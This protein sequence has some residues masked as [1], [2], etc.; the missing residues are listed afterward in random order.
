MQSLQFITFSA[1]HKLYLWWNWNIQLWKHQTKYGK[2]KKREF[3]WFIW[4]YKINDKII[5]RLCYTTILSTSTNPSVTTLGEEKMESSTENNVIGSA[6]LH[7]MSPHLMISILAQIFN[8]YLGNVLTNLLLFYFNWNK[9]NH[10]SQ[11][12]ALKSLWIEHC[13]KIH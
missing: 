12:V 11:V 4:N 7:K 3:H 2:V 1:A 13:D 9:L 6:P 10:K 5:F 8:G